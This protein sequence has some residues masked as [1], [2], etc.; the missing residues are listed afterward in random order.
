MVL[1]DVVERFP[2]LKALSGQ[3]FSEPSS[4]K[5]L[6]LFQVTHIPVF[7]HAPCNGCYLRNDSFVLLWFLCAP[8]KGILTWIIFKMWCFL[9]MTPEH[10]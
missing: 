1:V 3:R 9:L 5:E 8:C 10:P 6:R 4:G 7:C 2:S